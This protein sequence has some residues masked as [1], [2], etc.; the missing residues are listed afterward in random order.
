[1]PMIDRLR[2][3][4]RA[5]WRRASPRSRR[6]RRC[7]RGSDDASCVRAAFATIRGGFGQCT[8][9]RVAA[10]AGAGVC[11]GGVACAMRVDEVHDADDL[12]VVARTAKRP[13]NA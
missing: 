7:R 5:I 12:H 11:G 8:S 9:E 3:F 1:M 13:A 6:R 4:F 10:D 2:L